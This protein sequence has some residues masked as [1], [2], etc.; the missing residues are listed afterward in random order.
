MP[1]PDLAATCLRK[2]IYIRLLRRR[3]SFNVIRC[4]SDEWRL[5]RV[6]GQ[7]E[8]SRHW[9]HLGQSGRWDIFIATSA[10]RPNADSGWHPV[11]ERQLPPLVR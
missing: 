3:H 10:T 11:L 1:E 8:A 4:A 9:Q 7:S 5:P 2:W 6:G